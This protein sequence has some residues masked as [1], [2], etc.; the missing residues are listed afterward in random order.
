M[1]AIERLEIYSL[2]RNTYGFDFV[3]SMRS[4]DSFGGLDATLH[5]YR[6]SVGEDF[7]SVVIE[8]MGKDC[9]LFGPRCNEDTYYDL[10]EAQSPYNSKHRIAPN[11]F[12]EKI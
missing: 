3:K 8:S 4:C 5:P 10:G 7:F 1:Q 11:F 6:P 2:L 12:V 9:R